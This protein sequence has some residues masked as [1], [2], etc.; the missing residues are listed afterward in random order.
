MTTDDTRPLSGENTERL[1]Q[2]VRDLA[3][4]AALC[5]DQPCGDHDV[6]IGIATLL[7][8]TLDAERARHA[9]LVAEV[10]SDGRHTRPL[11]ALLHDYITTSGFGSCVHSPENEWIPWCEDMANRERDRRDALVA[12][13]SDLYGIAVGEHGHDEK[14]EPVWPSCLTTHIALNRARAALDGE[15]R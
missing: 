9:A 6:P 3:D 13:A 8:A 4:D 11:A 12:A 7:L 10:I 15:P 2:I 5:P 14:H 1:S